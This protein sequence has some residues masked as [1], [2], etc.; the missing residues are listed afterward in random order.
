VISKG[1][2]CLLPPVGPSRAS[3]AG[4]VGAHDGQVHAFQRGRL[5]GKVAAGVDRPADPRVDGFNGICRADHGANVG[6]E[7]Q[8][9]DKLRPRGLPQFDDRRVLVA[10]RLGEGD[11]RIQGGRFAGCGVA[12]FEILGQC[13][14][15]LLGGVAEAVSEQVVVMPTFSLFALV[16]PVPA[17]RMSAGPTGLLGSHDAA[18][19]GFS[20]APEPL[21]DRTAG[22]RGCRT[23]PGSV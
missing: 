14:P 18:A 20:C 19:A 13:R 10:P 5:G 3:A 21:D 11:E 15:V 1:V 22:G 12:R 8:E 7:L 17:L 4:R 16:E 9:W 2:E 23:S 6:V